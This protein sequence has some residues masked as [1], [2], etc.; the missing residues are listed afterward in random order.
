LIIDKGVDAIC[1]AF[2]LFLSLSALPMQYAIDWFWLLFLVVVISANLSQGFADF[3]FGLGI[4][5]F[6]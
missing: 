2:V 4:W 3:L 1:I 6:L 5:Q